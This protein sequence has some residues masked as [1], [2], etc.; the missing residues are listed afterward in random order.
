MLL[1]NISCKNR[2]VLHYKDESKCVKPIPCNWIFTL[3]KIPSPTYQHG[4]RLNFLFPKA[5]NSFNVEMQN[6]LKE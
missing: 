3:Y 6:I 1:Y 4:N 2:T 5:V